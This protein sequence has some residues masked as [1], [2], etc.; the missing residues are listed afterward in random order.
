VVST[1]FGGIGQLICA[2]AS[3]P[4]APRILAIKGAAIICHSMAF[5]YLD[6][7]D[8]RRLGVDLMERSHCSPSRA[9]DNNVFIVTANLTGTFGGVEFFG[10]SRITNPQGEVIAM[11]SEGV[12]ADELLVADLDLSERDEGRLPFRL[13]DRRRP[14]IYADILT[15]NPLSGRV[16]WS[17]GAGTETEAEPPPATAR[18]RHGVG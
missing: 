14:E 6:D 3:L 4:E 5:F 17:G 18:G 9:I 2:D 1:P 16:A 12:G 10:R 7:R 13:I 8:N 15:P 11:A